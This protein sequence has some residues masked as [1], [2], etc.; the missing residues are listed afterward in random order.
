MIITTLL[1]KKL[2]SD[3]LQCKSIQVKRTTG[4]PLGIILT[5]GE[6]LPVDGVELYTNDIRTILNVCENFNLFYENLP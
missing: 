4:E 6:Y 5:S 2:P 1:L 3:T